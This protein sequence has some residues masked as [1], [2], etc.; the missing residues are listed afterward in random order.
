MC[1]FPFSLLLT[2][3]NRITKN[4]KTAKEKKFK[5]AIP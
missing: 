5:D 4:G 1:F 3:K 2:F